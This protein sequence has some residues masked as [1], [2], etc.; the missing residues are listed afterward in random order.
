MKGRWHAS[1]SGAPHSASGEQLK[2]GRELSHNIRSNYSERHGV[3]TTKRRKRLLAITSVSLSVLGFIVLAEVVLRC[4]PVADSMFVLPVTAENPI[5]RYTPQRKRTIS[6]DWNLRLV[7]HVRVNN[8]GW[9]NEQD[10]Q[11]EDPIP[12][13]AIIGDSFIEADAVPYAQTVQGRL[14]EALKARLRVY[15]FGLNGAP[16]SQYLIWAQY[17]VREFKAEALVINVVGNDF[18]ESHISYQ[19]SPGFWVYAPDSKGNLQ[20]RLLEFPVGIARTL[21]KQSALARYLLLNMHL[22]ETL[23]NLSWLRELITGHV[24]P[25]DVPAYAGNTS[26]ST[27]PKRLAASMEVID[28]FFRDLP[29]L[30]GLP[31]DRITFTLDGFRYPDVA[32]QGAGTYFDLMRRAFREQAKMHGYQ[33]IDLDP[34][35]FADYR[36]HHQRFDYL[37]IDGHWNSA[38]HAILTQALLASRLLSSQ[39]SQESASSSSRTATANGPKT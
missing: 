27:D 39:L 35:F 6:H 37:P 8:D 19:D 16:L 9:V 33:V 15:S 18:D 2:F 7:S 26:V 22:K 38:G 25:R 34:L 31:A 5:Y 14:A 10:Y 21:L 12:L 30:T 32:V 20:L 3:N 17:A 11:K 29:R 28:A 1:Q 36:S 4:L 23:S 13:L 24:R